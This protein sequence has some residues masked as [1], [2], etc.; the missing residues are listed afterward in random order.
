MVSLERQRWPASAAA[1]WLTPSIRSPS[2]AITQVRWST[3]ERPKRAASRRSASAMPTAVEMPWPS[4]PVEAEFRVAGGGGVELAEL[5]DLLDA[6]A[7]VAG[8]VEQG[9][10]Q[11]GAVAGRQHETVAVWPA[12][13]GSVEFVEARPECGGDVGHAHRHARVAGFGCL[14]GIDGKGA[15]GSR[16]LG[17]VGG[18]SGGD[19]SRRGEHRI[20]GDGGVKGSHV[21]SWSLAGAY[22]GM[23]GRRQP[24]EI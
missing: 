17:G 22:R 5:L 19:L 11:H 12:W 16:H 3:R 9:V 13:V 8:E 1:S 23:G 10:E 7:V 21:V 18:W 4:G 2:E 15:E 24:Q 6:H 20:I 14:Q